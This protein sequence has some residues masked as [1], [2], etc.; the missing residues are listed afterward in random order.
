[1]NLTR[2]RKILYGLEAEIA[3]EANAAQDA[4]SKEALENAHLKCQDIAEWFLTV[5]NRER[6]MRNLQGRNRAA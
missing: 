5:E 6:E 4:R 1:V 2:A 3:K